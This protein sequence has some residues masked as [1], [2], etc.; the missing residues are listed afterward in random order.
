VAT[1]TLVAGLPFNRAC[2]APFAPQA[3]GVNKLDFE[4]IAHVMIL[5][6]DTEPGTRGRQGARKEILPQKFSTP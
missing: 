3:R 6:R 4:S 5:D 1:F 2:V